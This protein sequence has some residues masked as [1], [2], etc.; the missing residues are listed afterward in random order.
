MGALVASSSSP[1]VELDSAT[2]S[3]TSSIDKEDEVGTGEDTEEAISEALKVIVSSAEGSDAEAGDSVGSAELLSSG[4]GAEGVSGTSLTGASV[5]AGAATVKIVTVETTV[6]VSAAAPLAASGN[7]LVTSADPASEILDEEGAS[8][9]TEETPESEAVGSI[10]VEGG[11]AV[12]SVASGVSSCLR[13][14]RRPRKDLGVGEAG[15]EEADTVLESSSHAVSSSDSDSVSS[16][17][18]S[19]KIPPAAPVA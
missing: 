6:T 9:G 10:D 16:S 5:G 18:A 2:G 4:S 13:P 1:E 8:V 15:T 3:E 19:P 17:S 14:K 11:I 12:I 7:A